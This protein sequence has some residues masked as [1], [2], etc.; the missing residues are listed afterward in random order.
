MV[1]VA[2]VL[3][4]VAQPLLESLKDVALDVVGVELRLM[5]VE[6]RE[7]IPHVLLQ[8]FF[9]AI[10]GTLNRIVHFF[11][12]VE[13]SF[14][15]SEFSTQRSELLDLWGEAV[16]FFLALRVNLLHQ[17]RQLLE[18]LALHVV[19]L[20]FKLGHALN[21]VLNLGVAS[22]S[23]RFLKILQ[24]SIPIASSLLENLL[25]TVQHSH[26][27]LN[28][29]KALLHILEVVV[30]DAQGGGVLLEVITFQV[31][32]TFKLLVAI[33]LVT[34][35]FL[36]GD[37]FH[38]DLVLLFSLRVFFLAD[39]IGLGFVNRELVIGWSVLSNFAV[40]VM[41]FS[42]EA[43]HVTRE[44]LKLTLGGLG[45]LKQHL[46]ALKSLTF[47]IK[48]TANDIVANLAVLP[49][50]VTQIVKHLLGP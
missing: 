13:F 5:V 42:L 16:L 50:L 17:C 27:S 26:L 37:L 3:R 39:G 41:G 48:F 12:L 35:H 18:R 34:H 7:L 33:F 24:E 30:F 22:D 31:F 49:C 29:V 14:N 1:R 46:N 4:L 21:L 44:P 19:Q 28:L 45:L 32:A 25:S 36:K 47:V 23:L 15:L 8:A 11:L 9:L 10:D 43:L 38:L 20:L 2:Q 6:F 40:K